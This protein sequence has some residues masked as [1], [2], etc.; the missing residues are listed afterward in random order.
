[1]TRQTA[2]RPRPRPSRTDGR[3]WARQVLTRLKNSSPTS[4]PV[5]RRPVRA[6][7]SSAVLAVFLML[8]P[9]ASSRRSVVSRPKM[10]RRPGSTRM[11]HSNTVNGT[12][13]RPTNGASAFTAR[14]IALNRAPA[15]RPV[16]PLPTRPCF[17]RTLLP[18]LPRL[19][20]YRLI[21]RPW[22]RRRC[23][24]ARSPVG[25]GRDRPRETRP[26]LG[27]PSAAS[28]GKVLRA[29]ATSRS[30][31]CRVTRVSGRRSVDVR[32]CCRAAGRRGWR[33]R[34]GAAADAPC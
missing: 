7:A 19:R 22:R 23:R 31:S 2:P 21:A 26:L 6:S 14:R 10:T 17:T 4:A 32:M 27:H 8:K 11:S 1:M 20:L 24:P 28:R 18:K 29:A 15:A 12:D 34:G 9:R 3:G 30:A 16:I 13:G 5:T 33:A 25:R